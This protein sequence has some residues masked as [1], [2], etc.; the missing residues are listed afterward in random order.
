MSRG[1]RSL[2]FEG[3]DLLKGEA[4]PIEQFRAFPSLLE[5]DALMAHILRKMR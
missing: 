3:Q 4:L 5:S 1:P 2:N